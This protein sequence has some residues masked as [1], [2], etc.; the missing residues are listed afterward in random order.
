[1]V[2]VRILFISII[3]NNG[4]LSD[5][6]KLHNLTKSLTKMSLTKEPA[7]LIASI[8]LTLDNIAVSWRLL[9]DRYE[10]K[11]SLVAGKISSIFAHTA[12]KTESSSEFRSL[13]HRTAKALSALKASKAHS[14]QTR[15]T[16]VAGVRVVR[17]L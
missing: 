11:H 1:M 8:P 4:S 2:D 10:Y 12:M 15:Q 9:T 3:K 14:A 6:E 7:P 5:T 16:I 17:R 13:H